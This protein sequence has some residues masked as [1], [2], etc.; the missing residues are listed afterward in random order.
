MNVL[1]NGIPYIPAPQPI[2]GPPTPS[3][4]LITNTALGYSDGVDSM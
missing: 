2:Q 1:I 4:G 3:M